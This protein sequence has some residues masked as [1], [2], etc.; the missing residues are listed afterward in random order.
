MSVL[1][2]LGTL[3]L[4]IEGYELERLQ[5]DVSSDFTRVSTHIRL[6]G[7][8]EEGVG[9][10]V[11]YDAEDQDALQEAGAVQ[12]LDGKWTLDAFCDHVATLDLWP[13]PALR[14]PSVLY[15]RWANRRRWSSHCDRTGCRCTSRWAASRARSTSSSRCG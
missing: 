12:P 14:P 4:N 8:G 6:H 9:E 15:R 5:R 7:D 1:G 13:R 3:A 2:D 10:D 11:T